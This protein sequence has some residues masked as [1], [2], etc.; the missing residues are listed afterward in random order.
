MEIPM[1]TLTV[2][3]LIA[4]GKLPKS[5]EDTRRPTG[6]AL[7]KPRCMLT[8]HAE[9]VLL[10]LLLGSPFRLGTT[11]P[12]TAQRGKKGVAPHRPHIPLRTTLRPWEI[13]GST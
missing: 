5:A 12:Q 3:R 13:S 11:T 6:K 9:V 8:P 2:K 1:Y 10:P 4:A 7:C